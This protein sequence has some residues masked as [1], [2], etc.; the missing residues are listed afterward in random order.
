MLDVL[1]CLVA[2]VVAPAVVVLCACVLALR[3]AMRRSHNRLQSPMHDAQPSGRY[4][5]AVSMR[6]AS[7]VT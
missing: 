6:D 7:E 2:V 4:T 5:R 3:A 1:M